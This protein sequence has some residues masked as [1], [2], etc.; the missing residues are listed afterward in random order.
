MR[1]QSHV[2]AVAPEMPVHHWRFSFDYL[3]L[4]IPELTSRARN[5]LHL[6]GVVMI[7]HHARY[8][9]ETLL[10]LPSLVPSRSTN[11]IPPTSLPKSGL[12]GCPPEKS[13]APRVHD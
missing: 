13:P 4:A 9:K 10:C 12:S 5:E 2:L 6:D 7:D 1:V 3:F 8:H 11:W